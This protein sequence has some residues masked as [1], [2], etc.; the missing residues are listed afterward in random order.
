MY[1][2]KVR[3]G[4]YTEVFLLDTKICLKSLFSCFGYFSWGSITGLVVYCAFEK[5]PN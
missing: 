3:K 5:S 2:G 4:R 1:I